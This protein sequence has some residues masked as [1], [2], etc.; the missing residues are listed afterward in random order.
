MRTVFAKLLICFGLLFVTAGTASGHV[1][2]AD[3]AGANSR[4]EYLRGKFG[5]L[6]SQELNQRINLR[7]A[8]QER[9]QFLLETQSNRE[10]GAVLATVMDTKTGQIFF[11]QN[12]GLP[13]TLEPRLGER[14]LAY[15]EN[16]R[17]IYEK[18]A[19]GTHAE[20]GALND[21]LL[22]RPGAE[23]S[24]FMVNTIWLR[25]SRSGLPIPRCPHCETLTT[26][27]RYIPEPLQYGH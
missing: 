24:D 12:S 1:V 5:S 3:T 11:G 14:L 9:Y 15:P 26:G 17:P 13:A 23:M 19:P 25:G 16:W 18:A 2:V 20:F 10:R 27:V 22:A 6:S 7:G 21:A 8:A 4:L